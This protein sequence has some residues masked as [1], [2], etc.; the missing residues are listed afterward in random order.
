[1]KFEW[2]ENIQTLQ[3][4]FYVAIKARNN[5]KLKQMQISG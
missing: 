5:I 1:M 2:F 3:I 4:M